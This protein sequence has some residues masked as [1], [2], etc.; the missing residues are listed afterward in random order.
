MSKNIFYFLLLFVAIFFQF[1]C[2]NNNQHETNNNHRRIPLTS[3]LENQE[4]FYVFIQC[5]Q[6]QNL[7]NSIMN[8]INQAY[9]SSDINI[10]NLL[11]KLYN[12][13]YEVF[14]ICYNEMKTLKNNNYNNNDNRR[15]H[16]NYH[17]RTFYNVN[18]N[19]SYYNNINQNITLNNTNNSN[20]NTNEINNFYTFRYN[21]DNFKNCLEQKLNQLKDNEK[22]NN[23]INNLIKY[24][25]DKDYVNALTEEFKLNSYGNSIIKDCLIFK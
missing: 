9:N 14:E 5:L 8:E 1:K 3:L 20:N 18:P 16:H 10:I 15:K 24:I 25:N 23:P 7:G 17:N 6:K 19:T 22:L 13:S 2:Q 21:W 4:Y 11:Y 12:N